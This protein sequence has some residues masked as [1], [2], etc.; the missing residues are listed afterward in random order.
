MAAGTTAASS[1]QAT[2][3]AHAHA[4]GADR[5]RP[6]RGAVSRGRGRRRHAPHR[7]R[8]HAGRL[9]PRRAPARRPPR[10][11]PHQ[12][13]PARH[14]QRP[15]RVDLGRN[16]RGVVEVD[17]Y[18]VGPSAGLHR[19]DVVAAR[20]GRAVPGGHQQQL[21][22]GQRRGVAARHPGEQAGEAS[23]TTMSKSSPDAGPSVPT[24]PVRRPGATPRAGVDPRSELGPRDRR[25]ARRRGRRAARC[26]RRRAARHGRRAPGHRAPRA[27]RTSPARSRTRPAARRLVRVLG[28]VHV[29]QCAAAGRARAQQG[30]ARGQGVA[31][32]P[33]PSSIRSPP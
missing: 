12:A 26:R 9:R 10:R 20:G 22:G 3:P 25:C 30:G 7:R 24:R 17:V 33:Y 13:G 15:L 23:C 2:E 11:H 6:T 29:H 18:Q 19:P 14:A 27:A 28:H 8:L 31:C 1:P 32:G 21:G 16:E 4:W 5:C